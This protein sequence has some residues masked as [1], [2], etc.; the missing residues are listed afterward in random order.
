MFEH[1][2]TAKEY[3]AMAIAEK[4]E[5]DFDTGDR[6]EIREFTAIALTDGVP[7]SRQQQINYSSNRLGSSADAARISRYLQQ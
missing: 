5:M 6:G 4:F 2:T 1:P 7:L 3:L